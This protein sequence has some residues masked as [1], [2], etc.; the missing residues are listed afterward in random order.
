M[1]LS[2]YALFAGVAAVIIGLRI[3]DLGLTKNP[4]LSGVGFILSGMAGMLSPI[5]LRMTASLAA[6]ILAVVICYA[7]VA[8]WALTSYMAYWA[9]LLP[10]TK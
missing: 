9:H 7:V 10:P 2:I 8:I 6:R 1:P 5:F 4:T 3:I